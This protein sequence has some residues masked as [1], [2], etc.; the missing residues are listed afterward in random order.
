VGI[1]AVDADNCKRIAHP[2]ASM[3][4]QSVGVPVTATVSMFHTIQDMKFF[5]GT[6]YGNSTAFAGA[7]GEIKTQG[8]C[9]G[10]SAA[11]AGWLIMNIMMI[12][13]HKRKNHGVHLVGPI[14]KDNLHVVGT[15]YVDDTNIEHF[16]THQVK[17]VVEAHLNFQES[18]VNWGCLLI[19][20]G[21][22]LKPSKCFFQL[23][24]FFWRLMEYEKNHADLEY[25]IV[26]PLE[27]GS[28]A[29]IE[30]LDIDTPT[31]TLGSMTAPM[32]SNAGALT[33]MKETAE[34]RIAQAKLGN[35]H[36]R[37]V[38][39]LL[40][41]QIWP[42]VAYGNSTISAS[43][44]ELDECLMRTYYDLHPISSVRKSIRKE[45]RQIDRFFYGVS[46]PHL[47]VE[48]LL[49]QVLKLISH[50][51]SSSGIGK[52]MQVSMKLFII[53]AGI[54]LQPLAEQYSQYSKWVTHS[55]LK[56]LWEKVDLFQL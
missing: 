17:T 49:R 23:I 55:W 39:S 14:T 6:G 41:K 30:N 32:G 29:E 20:T 27:D 45:L 34:G 24:S 3:A 53:E 48:C 42:K 16:D 50:Y 19:A 11:P 47:G 52:H 40:D 31:K 28:H 26:V 2:I 1:A 51:G 5:L 7:T 35:L 21:G 10:N 4:F 12:R 33:Q 15:T 37:N 46:F 25:R 22:T 44:Q 8:L 56:L 13:A 38:W 36:T 54:S 43:F 9:Q 18:I